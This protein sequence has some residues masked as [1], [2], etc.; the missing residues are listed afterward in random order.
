MVNNY[1]YKLK[2]ITGIVFLFLFLSQIMA[3][4]ITENII[5]K[6]PDEPGNLTPNNPIPIYLNDYFVFVYMQSTN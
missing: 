1:C 4:Q 5:G 3:F 6:L 2:K